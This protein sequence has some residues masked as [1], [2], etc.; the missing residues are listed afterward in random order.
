MLF[1]FKLLL[2]RRRHYRRTRSPKQ[3]SEL[4]RTVGLLPQTSRA[5][6]AGKPLAWEKIA[7]R[8]RKTNPEIRGVQT[9]YGEDFGSRSECAAEPAIGK[10]EASC[11]FGTRRT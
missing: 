3:P 10:E 4:P 11:R 7:F 1:S 8:P 5:L 6:A 9:Y 2:L